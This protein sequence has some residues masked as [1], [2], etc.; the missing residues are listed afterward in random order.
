MN[1]IPSKELLVTLYV[2]RK[3]SAKEISRLLNC[4]EHKIH[5]WLDR[6][7]IFQRS[8]SDAL[9]IKHNPN[10][11]PFHIKRPKTIEEGVLFGMG[12][13][14]YW[15]EGTKRNKNS[16]RLGNTDPKLI[17]K[18][19]EFLRKMYGV[20]MSKLHFGLQIFSDMPPRQALQFWLNHLNVPAS[21]FYKVTVTPARS[22][23]TY[24]QKTRYGVL[25]VYCNNRKLRD[26]ICQ[27]IENI[28]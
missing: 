21:Q 8:I 12:I 25:T 16:I 19:I 28:K 24:R 17:R 23:G 22:I 14:L 3:K 20:K 15:G 27:T 6:Y 4:S 5:Y 18:F 2:R 11:D 1:T 13:G 10:G 9:Y 7:R 26:I